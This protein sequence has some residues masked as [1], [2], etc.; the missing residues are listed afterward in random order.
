MKLKK[1]EAYVQ[2]DKKFKEHHIFIPANCY[3]P[4]TGDDNTWI[5]I[6]IRIGEDTDEIVD[7]DFWN[8]SE[9]TK[10][11]EGLTKFKR[12]SKKHT[13]KKEAIRWFKNIVGGSGVDRTKFPNNMKGR[14]ARKNWNEPLFSL[15]VEYGFLIALREIYGITPKDL[16][17]GGTDGK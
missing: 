10:F 12:V 13:D 17:G 15:G 4:K 5:K 7:T 14:I 9:I 8:I 2:E 1:I 11:S 6:T 3:D 16:Q